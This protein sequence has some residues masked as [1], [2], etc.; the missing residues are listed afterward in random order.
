[1]Y[2][3]RRSMLNGRHICDIPTLL[4]SLLAL[5]Q[6]PD[7]NHR[8]GGLYVASAHRGGLNGVLTACACTAYP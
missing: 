8:D 4:P 3:V 6:S 1:M 7:D 5:L 2:F